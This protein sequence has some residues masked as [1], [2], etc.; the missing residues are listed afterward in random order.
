[1]IG[2]HCVMCDSVFYFTKP[3]YS[4]YCID[5]CITFGNI[6]VILST[7]GGGHSEHDE[8]I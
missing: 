3:K 4:I 1:M 2:I 8:S 5:L 6:V 7:H